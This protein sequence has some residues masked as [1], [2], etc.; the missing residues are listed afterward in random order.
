MADFQLFA[1][2]DGKEAFKGKRNPAEEFNITRENGLYGVTFFTKIKVMCELA[3]DGQACWK[4]VLEQ[5]G[6][7]KGLP[8]P[9]C[10]AAFEKAKVAL[11]EPALVTVRARVKNIKSP[12]VEFIPGRATCVP[13]PN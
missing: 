4:K 5:N 7:P 1:S 8:M 13:E 2:A 9:D 6:A 12:K 3:A 11:T 10:K